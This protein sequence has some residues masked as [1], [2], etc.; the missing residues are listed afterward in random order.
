MSNMLLLMYV[1]QQNKLAAFSTNFTNKND[2]VS[3]LLYQWL[4]FSISDTLIVKYFAYAIQH[5][6]SLTYH[7]IHYPCVHSVIFHRYHSQE[8]V[9]VVQCHVCTHATA[10]LTN[11]IGT[12]TNCQS[13]TPWQQAMEVMR[14]HNGQGPESGP[15]LSL[16]PAAMLVSSCGP[17]RDDPWIQVEFSFSRQS[18]VFVLP[19]VKP[20]RPSSKVHTAGSSSITSPDY[21]THTNTYITLSSVY[22]H[23]SICK[24]PDSTLSKPITGRFI[25]ILSKQCKLV[26]L[27]GH[28]GKDVTCHRFV[29]QYAA[30]MHFL[31]HFT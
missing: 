4:V 19:C 18:R 20:R 9:Y 24:F 27:Q 23:S 26:L 6:Q 28:W 1:T 5:V 25:F 29:I 2:T 12:T 22:R 10:A 30:N 14:L 7:T 21:R 11:L 16:S 31:R 13:T 17:V 3:T 15:S 8:F